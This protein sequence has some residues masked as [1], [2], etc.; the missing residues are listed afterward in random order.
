M[1]KVKHIIMELTGA[2]RAAIERHTGKLESVKNDPRLVR[3][4]EEFVKVARG[5]EDKG[6][7]SVATATFNRGTGHAEAAADANAEADK[8]GTEEQTGVTREDSTP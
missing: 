6:D 1:G 8:S 3:V 7:L 5:V 2:E 4:P